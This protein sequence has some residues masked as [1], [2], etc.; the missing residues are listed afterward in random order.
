MADKLDIPDLRDLA[1]EKFK[2]RFQKW[3]EHDCAAIVSKVL[4]C[5]STNDR[6]L[7][8]VVSTMCVKHVEEITGGYET[9]EAKVAE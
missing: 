4:E 1:A 8:P 5:T 3:P 2:A 9:D 7:R 6:G